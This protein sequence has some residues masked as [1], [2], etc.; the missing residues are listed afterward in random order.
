MNQEAGHSLA[1][2]SVQDV[3]QLQS[4]YHP[5]CVLIWRLS[6]EKPPIKL[7]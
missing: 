6:Q 2:L 5:G 4:K 1:R 7:I 3:P